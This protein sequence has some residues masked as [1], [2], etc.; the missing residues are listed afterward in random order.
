MG[1]PLV[2]APLLVKPVPEFRGVVP[3]LVLHEYPKI[4]SPFA[5]VVVGVDV[6]KSVAVVVT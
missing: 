5:V 6:M 2:R 3:S 1:T 4:R